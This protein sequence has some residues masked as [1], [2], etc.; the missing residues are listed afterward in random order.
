[1]LA[2]DSYTY[3]HF[4]MVA[5][6]VFAAVG[7]VVLI[8]GEDHLAQGRAALYGGL[9]VYLLGQAVFRLRNV[10]GVNRPRAVVAVALLVGI[11]A[12]DAA[13]SLVQLVAPAVVLVAL[14]SYE[15][16][17]FRDA[18]AEIRHGEAPDG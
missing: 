14:V 1:M 10:G 11:P 2:R 6:I 4:P 15:V 12:F 3:V 9:V 16:W 13:S 5:G 7:L 18:R 8:R 17:A